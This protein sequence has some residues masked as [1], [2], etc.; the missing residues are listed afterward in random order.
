[1][2]SLENVSPVNSLSEIY[3]LFTKLYPEMKAQVSGW[4]P[5]GSFTEYFRGIAVSFQDGKR[6]LFSV[7]RSPDEEG[8]NVSGLYL[9]PAYMKE[10]P[11][12]VSRSVP[13]AYNG[14]VETPEDLLA[15]FLRMFPEY[16]YQ[17][18][19]LQVWRRFSESYRGIMIHLTDRKKVLF[20]ALKHQEIWY[21]AYPI[22]V[23]SPDEEDVPRS[24]L[25]QIVMSD[26][27]IFPD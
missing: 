4:Q 21:A 19:D 26:L 7:G 16:R 12:D 25:E 9:V 17:A 13:A 24:E 6:L 22:L 23:P 5:W 18:V 20:A 15:F 10:I 14:P 3:E 27:V 2:K 11:E 1:M 8:W